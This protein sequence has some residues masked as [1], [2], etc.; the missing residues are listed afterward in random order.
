MKYTD[1]A[2]LWWKTSIDP[3]NPVRDPRPIALTVYDELTFTYE[4]EIDPETGEVTLSMNYVIGKMRDLWIFQWFLIVIPLTA[5]YNATG[6]FRLNGQQ[7]SIETIHDSIHNQGI[8]MSTVN[9]QGTVIIDNTAYF[10]KV[11]IGTEKL[12]MLKLKTIGVI[13]VVAGFYFL[14][15]YLTWIFFGKPELWSD[16]YAWFLGHN[17]DLWALSLPL[18]GLPLLFKKSS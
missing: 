9:F 3:D 6:C 15:N 10:S 4:F 2:A 1:L 13:I 18:L 16:W 5:H 17:L 8:Q 12:E 14:W 11:S 7:I